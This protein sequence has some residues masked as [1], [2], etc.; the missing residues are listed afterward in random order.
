MPEVT[1]QAHINDLANPL[2]TTLTIIT[3][4][5]NIDADNLDTLVGKAVNDCVEIAVKQGYN[6][7]DI[8][9]VVNF[10]E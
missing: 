4:P 8:I 5:D 7:T 10:R 1:A 9:V 2:I 3:L 6:P